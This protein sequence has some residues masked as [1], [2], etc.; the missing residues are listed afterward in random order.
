MRFTEF[1][2]EDAAFGWL[3]S[4]GYQV[5]RGPDIAFGELSAEH[6]DPAYRDMVLE[7]RLPEA[8]ARLN[9]DLP[10][11][12]LEDAYRKL[13]HTDAPSLLERNHVVYRMLVEGVTVEYRRKDSSIAGAQA[14]GHRLR[15]A[16]LQ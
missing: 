10:H 16:G 3:K 12:A 6:N 15:R 5:L 9:T 2:V 13:T 7:S 11:E 14:R 1:V 4:L 8:L